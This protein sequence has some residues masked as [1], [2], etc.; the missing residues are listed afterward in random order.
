MIEKMIKGQPLQAAV[1][2]DQREDEEGWKIKEVHHLW[3][4]WPQNVSVLH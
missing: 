2:D 3:S 4:G 1:W